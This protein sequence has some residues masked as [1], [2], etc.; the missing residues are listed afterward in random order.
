MGATLASLTP[1]VGPRVGVSNVAVRP[2]REQSLRWYGR[3][4]R[5]AGVHPFPPPSI[6]LLSQL[7]VRVSPPPPPLL[8]GQQGGRGGHTC[9]LRVIT[10]RLLPYPRP[11]WRREGRGRDGG[12]RR[13]KGEGA[14]CFTSAE[15]IRD[16]EVRLVGPPAWR[17]FDFLRS[18]YK[19]LAWKASHWANDQF[20][21]ELHIES[22][23][24]FLPL[25]L[26]HVGCGSLNSHWRHVGATL[27]SVNPRTKSLI[28]R[29]HDTS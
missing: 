22:L 26:A 18:V 1:L 5:G 16:S 4:L 17:L 20:W 6:S 19:H 3:W 23:V 10:F 21:Q 2:R 27:T 15:D 11:L 12:G 9:L 24:Q 8:R 13:R 25:H 28:T 7:I 29:R 14:A